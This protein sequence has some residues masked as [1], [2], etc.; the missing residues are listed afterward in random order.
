[1]VEFSQQTSNQYKLGFGGDTLNTAIYLARCGGETDYFTV[2]GNDPYSQDMK[3]AWEIEG[4]GIDHVKCTDNK[5]PGLYVIKNDNSGERYFH[6][7]RDNSPARRLL[8]EFPEVFTSLSNYQMIFLSGITLSLY[9]GEDLA[10]LFSFLSNYRKAG[11]KVVFDNNYRQRNWQ[12]SAKAIQVFLQMMSHVDIALLSFD[13]EITLYGEHSIDECMQRWREAGVSEI[14]IKNGQN[15]CS[16]YQNN[17]ASIVPLD[18]ICKPIDTTA[19]GDSFNGAYLAA[20]LRN[21]PIIECVK[22][23]QA[24]ASVVIMHKGAIIDRDISL[25]GSLT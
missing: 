14:V 1:M 4:V 17:S 10:T 22:A 11:G 25:Q 8:S 23:G 21:E 5:M 6:Y 20:K 7:W 24:C 9:S 12:S 3:T 18:E 16:V 19:A 13:D 2:L 15:G